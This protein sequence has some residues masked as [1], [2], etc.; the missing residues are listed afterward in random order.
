MA[1]LPTF[2]APLTAGSLGVSG[3]QLPHVP[4]S[5][6]AKR[7]LPF[8]LT[9]FSQRAEKKLKKPAKKLIMF[10]FLFLTLLSVKKKKKESSVY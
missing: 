9:L 1:F 8:R 3:S 5:E 10:C 7:A 2:P 6:P 4:S